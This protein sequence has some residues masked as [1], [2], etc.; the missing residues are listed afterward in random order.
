LLLF[1]QGHDEKPDVFT[2]SKLSSEAEVFV[3]ETPSTPSTDVNENVPEEET[4]TE[5]LF[6]YTPLL[7]IPFENL[8]MIFFQKLKTSLKWSTTPACLRMMRKCPLL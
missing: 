7:Y 1:Y 5:G 6:Y 2:E 3:A 4:A 8:F